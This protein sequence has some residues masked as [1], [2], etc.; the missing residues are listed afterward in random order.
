MKPEKIDPNLLL[1]IDEAATSPHKEVAARRSA[2][3]IRGG[4]SVARPLSAVVFLHCDPD[5]SLEEYDAMGVHVNQS[6]GRLRTALVRLDKLDSLSEDAR[7]HRVVAARKRRPLMDVAPG[8]VQ[9]P[10]FR[11]RTTAT[12]RGTLIGIVDSGVDT[13]HPAFGSRILSV[14][15]QQ[16][17]GTGIPGAR[18]GTELT[19][20]AMHNCED[21]VGHGTHVCGIAAGSDATFGGVAPEASIVVVKTNFSDPGIADG[22]AYV[23]RK[24]AEL[25]MPAVVNLSLGGHADAHD[26]TDELCQI[27]DSLTGPGRIICAAAGN[28]GD[29]SIHASVKIA[30]GATASV[31]FRV[32]SGALGVFLNGWCSGARTLQVSVTAASG[33]SSAFVDVDGGNTAASPSVPGAQFVVTSPPPDPSTGD[34]HFDALLTAHMGSPIPG[35]TWNIRIRNTS[36]SAAT[37]DLWIADS[38]PAAVF[39]G[40]SVSRSSLIGAPGAAS[41]ALTV[42]AY[43]TKTRWTALNGQSFESSLA[44]DTVSSFS[45]PGPLRGGARKPDLTAPGS[46]IV[47]AASRSAAPESSVVIDP[48]H[49]AMQGTSMATPFMTGLIACMLQLDRTLDPAAIK[50]RLFQHTKV[51]G[52]PVGTFDPKWG[53]GL[54]NAKEV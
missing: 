46:M 20:T 37:L 3:G 41:S 15:D 48:L 8:K 44:V 11:T 42:A 38:E 36:S 25:G 33:Q 51:P 52:Q 23:F 39:T 27:L 12:G 34:L 2:I 13:K 4:S 5:A 45:S 32:D 9:V 14:W 50:A 29:E 10:A 49:V 1:A 31:R 16:V 19:G 28:E 21:F 47:S 30:P 43:T 17:G 7:V 18:Y 53:F 24:A 22:V 6:R 54:I 26:G 35:G 40:N